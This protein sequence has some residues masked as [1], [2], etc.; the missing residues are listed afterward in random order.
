MKSL[1]SKIKS[2]GFFHVLNNESLHCFY[3]FILY[4]FT[5]HTSKIQ[6][7]IN[8]LRNTRYVQN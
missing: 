6:I 1:Q 5:H 4:I 2:H 7:Q 3:I 8:L